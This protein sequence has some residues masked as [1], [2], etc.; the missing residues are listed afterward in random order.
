[1]WLKL[2]TLIKTT[3]YKKEERGKRIER[4]QEQ[5]KHAGEVQ[6]EHIH[7][8]AKVIKKVVKEPDELPPWDGVPAIKKVFEERP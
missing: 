1:M 2:G 4:V 5:D 7:R 6:R 3:F 8:V